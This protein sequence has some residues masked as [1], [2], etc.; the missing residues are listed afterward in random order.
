MHSLKVLEFGSVTARLRNHCETPWA[1]DAADKLSPSFVDAAVWSALEET[2][3]AHSAIG[4]YSPPSLALVRDPRESL[5][6]ASKGATLS[7][8]DLYRIGQSLGA[9][10][11]LKQ[12]LAAREAEMPRL[13]AHKKNL[14]EQQKLEELLLTQLESDG[15]VKDSASPA[16]AT[17]RARRKGAQQR[18]QERIQS[19]ISGKT[20]ELLSD[21]IYTVRD[22]RYVLP[23]KAE[24]RGKIR[25]IVHDTSASGQTVYVEPEEILQLGNQLRE[26]EIA[27]REEV[28]RLYQL[29]SGKVGEVAD[30]VAAGVVAASKVDFVLA[31]ARLGYEMNAC[32][33][34]RCKTPHT[35]QVHAGRHPLLEKE[36][37]VPLDIVLGQNRNVLI[38]G[39]NTGGK[40]VAIKCVGLFV[41]M[42][43]S[44]LMLPAL[45][46][47]LA[48]FSQIWADIGDEQS[49]EQS[50]STFSG[51]LKNIAEALNR[52]KAGALV[53]LDEVGSGTDPAEGAALA[54]AILEAFASGG[55][56]IL[57]STHFGELKAFA[58]SKE[59]F[60]NAAMEFDAKS[61]RPTYRLMLGA[62]GASQAMR[63]AERYGISPAIVQTA[64]TYLSEEDQDIDQMFARLET[65]QKVARNAQAEADRRLSEVRKAEQTS[66]RKLREA[67]EIRMSVYGKANEVIETA[68]REIRLEAARLFEE[69]KAQRKEPGSNDRVREEL[70]ELDRVGKEFAAGFLPK[71][72]RRESPALPKGAYV[73]V[74]GLTQVGTVESEP[75]DGQ[76]SVR[77]GA[78]KMTVPVTRVELSGPPP[79]QALKAVGSIRL[80]K[81]INAT[82]EI[83]L[84][85]LR[86]EEAV[87]DLE[88]FL[89]DAVLAG[90]D[91]IRVV[92]GKGEGVLRKA[93]QSVLKGHPAVATYRDGE[94][95]EGGQGATVATLG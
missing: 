17:L 12:F 18:I 53:L 21:P 15:T 93:T 14:P 22:G 49:L 80:Q 30:E 48:P 25:G 66:N 78:V 71:R 1:M 41:A 51:H 79:K 92:H 20:R 31:K 40:T 42:A 32:L 4:R 2:E 28:R 38:T 90:L 39:P 59:G 95:A 50:L 46:V 8:Q 63:I 88:R 23:L 16:L 47:Q 76:V 7:G 9:M 54:R 67:E 19:F 52:L 13:S 29:W 5:L 24:N 70:R 89:D 37:V 11:A 64:Q 44:G 55:A 94:P 62:P 69:I 35:I 6:L 10:R 91:S 65:A 75:K 26:I 74:E 72:T 85:H 61:L 56:T 86:A 57:A 84:R 36:K 33:P 58:F 43:Q 83:D 3:E 68:L 60:T 87:R 81:T 27:E 45:S 82:T 34:E 77:M 73:K